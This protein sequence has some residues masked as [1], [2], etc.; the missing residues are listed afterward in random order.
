[1]A[2]YGS[3]TILLAED[4]EVVRKL[5][6]EVLEIYGYQVLEAANGGAALLIC[7]NHTEPIHL[8][9]TDIIMPEMSGSRLAER[10]RQLQPAMKVIFLSGY[11]DDAIVHQ[12]VLDEGT[13][14]IQKP[15]APD[16]LARHVRE[17]LDKSE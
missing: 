17:V 4:E 10:L 12:G 9:L 1:V 16:A 7:E 11:P 15:F 8:L 3:E 5:A 13:N 2:L 6:R 14:F